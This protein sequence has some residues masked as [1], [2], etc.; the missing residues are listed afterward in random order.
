VQSK[1]TAAPAAEG[2]APSGGGSDPGDEP[3]GPVLEVRDLHVSYGG[4]RALRDVSVTV[5]EGEIVA[6]LGNNGAGKSTLLRAISGTLPLQRGTVDSGSIALL[7]RN[8]AGL[9]PADV[10]RAGVVQVP[11]GRRIFGDLT[12]EENLRAGTFGRVTRQ[13]V[14]DAHQRVLELFPRL[15]ERSRQRAALLSG[16]E[17]QMLAIGRALMSDPKVLL[18]DEPS[19]GLA[20]QLVDRIGEI[21]QQINEQGTALVLVEQNAAMALKIAHHAFVLEVGSVA[22]KGPAKELATT[23]E[24]RKRYLGIAG[25]EEPELI[26]AEPI[27]RVTKD[28]RTPRPLA[29][30]D[31]TVHFGGLMALSEVS[32]R[33]EPGDT[34]AVIGP[35]GAGKST[36]L[37]VLTGVYRPS[38]GHVDYGGKTLTRMRPPEI[39]ALGISRTFQNLAL[40]PTATVREN[41]LL[42]RHRLSKAGFLTAG[43]RL[44]RARRELAEQERIVDGIGALWGLA[45][46]LDAR[47]GALPYGMRKRA[48]VARALCA[49]PSLLLLDEPVAGMNADESAEMA[50]SIVQTR[51]A[52]G[53]SIVLVE[54]DMPFVMGIAKRITVLDFGRVISD[55]TPH[56]VQHD[57]EVMRAYLGFAEGSHEAGEEA[58][59][60]AGRAEERSETQ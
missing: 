1:R 19:L 18:L 41:L 49:E 33:I 10:V 50:R 22:L 21:L 16:G 5:G 60:A 45:D 54:H 44:P 51:E 46:V 11:E 29:V 4:V 48:E 8:L 9:D 26:T 53:I 13:G 7:G 34:H 59:G 20:P 43:L 40:S 27:Q 35:N 39:A 38:S 3:R 31:L 52:L 47:M 42:G 58:R 28:K 36:L 6:V 25:E 37:N 14:A 23:N 15:R 56:D 55:G 17:Q 30:E 2:T 32:L 12:V 57:P 24:V